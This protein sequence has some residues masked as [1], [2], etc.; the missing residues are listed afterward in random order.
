MNEMPP[1]A[2]FAATC[3]A[4]GNQNN[5]ATGNTGN[6]GVNQNNQASG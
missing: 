1:E 3:N 4:A 2:P 5:Q 6:T